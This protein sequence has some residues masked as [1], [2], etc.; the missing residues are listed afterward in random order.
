MKTC[1]GENQRALVVILEKEKDSKSK[2]NR[3]YSKHIYKISG[4]RYLGKV[5]VKLL[6]MRNFE[7]KKYSMVL[8]MG[9]W[10]NLTFSS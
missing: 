4:R 3:K 7:A 8:V 2:W 1:V 5:N 9:I 10:G 6:R